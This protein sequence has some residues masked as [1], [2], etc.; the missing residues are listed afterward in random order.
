[1]NHLLIRFHVPAV[2]FLF[3][4]MSLPADIM[5]RF[6]ETRPAEYRLFNIRT[7]IT[8][9]GHGPQPS[10]LKLRD[11][12]GA[13]QVWDAPGAGYFDIVNVPAAVAADRESFFEVNDRWLHSR[14]LEK[15]QYLLVDFFGDAPPALPRIAANRPLPDLP[16]TGIAENDAG[17]VKSETQRGQVYSA[18]VTPARP[19]YALFRMTWHPAWKAYVDG[20]PR[21]TAM[22]SPGFIG[23]PVETGRHRLE[24]RY[25]PGP[26]KIEMAAAGWCLAL[27]VGIVEN[28]RGLPFLRGRQQLK[29]ELALPR[30]NVPGLAMPAGL[31][32]S[33]VSPSPAGSRRP[34][35]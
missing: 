14:W 13:M 4:A 9:S 20:K 34:L 18:V 28:K 19:A 21:R 30:K 26:S 3:H 17:A 16:L 24:L 25:Q 33:P 7:V 27:L 8:P 15:G 35:P 1:M 2:S 12:L 22:L 11:D 10:F 32:E 29:L 5:A 31:A 23:I 6:D